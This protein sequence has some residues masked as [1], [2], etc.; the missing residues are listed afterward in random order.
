MA[1]LDNI[2][3]LAM[4]IFM[5]GFAIVI[6]AGAFAALLA[7]IVA[8]TATFITGKCNIHKIRPFYLNW[9]R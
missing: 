9:F 6:L 1:L 8:T 5:A 7:A 4:A 3:L 2:I